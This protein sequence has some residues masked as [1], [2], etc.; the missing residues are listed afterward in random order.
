MAQAGTIVP[1]LN[2]LLLQLDARGIPY[3]SVS[4]PPWAITYKPEATQ[5]Q[6]DQGNA[7]VAAFDGQPRIFRTLTA[8]Y[9]NLQQLTQTQRDKI[10]TNLS[11]A[12]GVSPRRYLSDKGLNAGP[13]FNADDPANDTSLPAARMQAARMRIEAF[14]CQDNPYAFVNPAYDTSINVCGVE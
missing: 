11:A 4:G 8:I 6:K 3:E 10:W 1:A 12:D 2:V 7:I 13:I 9:Q 5:A 14:Y